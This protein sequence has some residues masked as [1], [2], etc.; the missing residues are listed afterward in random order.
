MSSAPSGA[1]TPFRVAV[2]T[3][4]DLGQESAAALSGLA[5]VEVVAIVTAPAYR[6]RPLPD[7]LRRLLRREGIIGLPAWLGR[8][9]RFALRPQR[10]PLEA[11]V[12]MIA[13]A[14]FHAPDGMAALRALDLDLLVVDGTGIL[15]EP[16]FTAARHGSVNLHC[17]Q[18]PQYRGA[19]PAFW[20]L[21][22]GERDVGVTVHRVTAQVDAGPILA[23][24]MLPLDPAPAMDP[25]AYAETVWRT[26]L[27][28][29]GLGLLREVVSGLRDGSIRETPQ[30]PSTGEAHRIP[31][32]GQVRE[33]RRRVRARRA[34]G[35]GGPA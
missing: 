20:E 14:D 21:Y 6:P 29:A 11:P 5:G 30:A 1:C 32:A 8:R 22:N 34:P 23:Q 31:D 7:R 28:P 3:S 25:V 24:C 18:L 19:P 35:T 26:K 2:L 12:R 27:R 16:V 17:G 15:R 10:K 13:L 4:S 9:L 33:L